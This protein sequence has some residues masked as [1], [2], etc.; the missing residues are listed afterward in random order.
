MPR[1]AEF[2]CDL[3]TAELFGR[4]VTGPLPLGLVLRG[5]EW[6]L[7]HDV[8]LDTSDQALARRGIA[9]RIRSVGE[10]RRS[11]ALGIGQPDLPSSG[12]SELFEAETRAAD[13]P[14]ILAGD[15]EPARRLR[16]LVE[17]SRLEARLA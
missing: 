14:G 16:E 10:E 7:C 2:R 4:L 12:P 6:R 13:L 15:T 5:V 3:P 11:I 1:A 8:Y 9:C 17:P